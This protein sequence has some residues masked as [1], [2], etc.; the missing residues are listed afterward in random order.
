MNINLYNG[1]TKFIEYKLKYSKTL[2]KAV[3]AFANYHDGYVVIGID[4]N[5]IV[6]GVDNSEATRLTLEN[7]I[8]DAIEPKPY[9]EISTESIKGKN[10]V[11]LKVYKGDHT[12]Y[13][14]NNNTY[15]RMDTSSVQVDRRGYQE[16]ILLGQNQ[17][18]ETLS[19][20]QEELTFDILSKEFKEKLK[21]SELSKDLLITL[22]LLVNG[23]YNNGA[24]LLSDKN[25]IKASTMQLVAYQD[26]TVKR[27]RDRQ[28]LENMSILTQYKHCID[29]YRKHINVSELI[30][31]PYR[32]TIEEVPIVAYREAIANLIVHRDYMRNV[33]AK[34]EVYSDRVEILSPGGLPI[35]V[36]EED[37]LDGRISIPRNRIL[38]D[39]FLRLKII[40]KLATGIKRIK[41]YYQD[42]DVKPI[43]RV[44]ENVIIVVLPK[45]NVGG[46]DNEKYFETILEGLND[47][48]Q[49]IFKL[50]K[51]DGAK[52]RKE[53]ELKLNLKKTQTSDLLRNMRNQDLVVQIGSG[54]STRYTL[55]SKLDRV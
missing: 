23:K 43:F 13:T 6:I 45:V 2:L 22:G 44:T 12:P 46:M 4:D 41:E 32:E 25:P 20:H 42:Y 40:E 47:H 24:A 15:T 53:I 11:V 7:A 17:S 51:Q 48:E 37:Y 34:V 27:I 26:N 19:I 16:L 55:S 33:D 18:F 39:I 5:G 14:F 21:V 8:N 1:E 9:Y 30:E 36:T 10:V 35:G 52:T 28:T 49:R 29:F 38:A 31:G 54:R 50:L 3:S